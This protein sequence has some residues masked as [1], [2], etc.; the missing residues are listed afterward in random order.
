MGLYDEVAQEGKPDRSKIGCL[1][2]SHPDAADDIRELL[3]KQP[4]MPQG[5]VAEKLC[6]EFNPER[7]I[8][9]ADVG[10]WRRNHR[11]PPADTQ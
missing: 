1:M 10:H 11:P 4:Q 9:P 6:A 8:F 3:L 5:K 7:R 2:A